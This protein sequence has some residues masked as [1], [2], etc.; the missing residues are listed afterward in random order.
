MAPADEAAPEAV[1]MEQIS[2]HKKTKSEALTAKSEAGTPF[3]HVIFRFPTPESRQ[4]VTV[5]PG[6]N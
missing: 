6:W 2:R 5:L 3:I 1:S 4:S